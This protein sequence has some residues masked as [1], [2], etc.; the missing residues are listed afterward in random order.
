MILLKPH[1]CSPGM[2]PVGSSLGSTWEHDL[3]Q[4][5]QKEAKILMLHQR[6]PSELVIEE[7]VKYVIIFLEVGKFRKPIFSRIQNWRIQSDVV[8]GWGCNSSDIFQQPSKNPIIYPIE[9]KIPI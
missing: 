5:G 4:Y 2:L 3:S 6:K 1:I 7:I 8:Y 9:H